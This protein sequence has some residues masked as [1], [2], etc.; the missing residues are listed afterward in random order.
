MRALLAVAALLCT[1]PLSAQEGIDAF[2]E[3]FTAEWIRGNPNLAT[4]TRYFSGDEQD[5]FERQLTPETLADL[6]QHVWRK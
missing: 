1:L 2:F 5:R 6:R 4:S 3:R